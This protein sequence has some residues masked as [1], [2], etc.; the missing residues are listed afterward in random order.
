MKKNSVFDFLLN[1]GDGL[2]E[3]VP[4][5]GA[6]YKAIKG[7]DIADTAIEALTGNQLIEQIAALPADQLQQVY[8]AEIEL[9]TTESNNF[10]AIQ[11]TLADADKTGN[12]TRPWCAKLIVST[13][14]LIDLCF[15]GGLL[16]S[17][18]KSVD[19]MAALKDC[20][21]LILAMLVP[22]LGVVNQYFG[23]RTEEK[24]NRARLAAGAAPE[25]SKGLIA[26]LLG[27]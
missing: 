10:A 16:V 25:H 27:R 22:L 2:L 17:A 7:T 21:P 5:I 13:V 20:W 4:G 9:Q 6:V 1:I 14:C 24:T 3:G 15:A 19:P 11:A 18:F 8:M 23:K 12:S 26:T